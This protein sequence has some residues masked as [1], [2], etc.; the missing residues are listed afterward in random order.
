M[1]K[2]HLTVNILGIS[3]TLK[4]KETPEHLKQIIQY[5]EGKLDEARGNL[6]TVDPCKLLIMAGLTI[7]DELLKERNTKIKHIEPGVDPEELEEF[8]ARMIN[9]IDESLMGH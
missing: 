2:N 3:L 7:T 1:E 6:V 8:T 5:F 4:S 9:K